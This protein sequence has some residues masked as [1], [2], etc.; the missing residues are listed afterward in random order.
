MHHSAVSFSLSW[1]YE[2][3]KR[4]DGL[5][6]PVDHNPSLPLVFLEVQMKRDPILL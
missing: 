3:K 4:F 5:L 1:L 6:T 2:N